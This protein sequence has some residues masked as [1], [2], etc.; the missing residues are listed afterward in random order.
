[1]SVSFQDL[2]LK[3]NSIA[4]DNTV[5]P[6]AVLLIECLKG[7]MEV[8]NENATLR[9]EI[10]ELRNDIKELKTANDDYEQRSRNECLV[11]HGIPESGD[12]S[13]ENTDDIVVKEISEKI[14]VPLSIVDLKNSHRLGPP[15]VKQRNTR[16]TKAHPRDLD[17]PQHASVERSS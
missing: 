5:P 3:L 15:K 2:C 13:I 11:L 12:G 8:F 4:N 9:N 1:M 16:T 7:F 10:T 6:W 17:W 14:G